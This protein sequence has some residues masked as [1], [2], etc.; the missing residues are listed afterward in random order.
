MMPQAGSDF[1]GLYIHQEYEGEHVQRFL[2][3]A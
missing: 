3:K 1:E 2:E